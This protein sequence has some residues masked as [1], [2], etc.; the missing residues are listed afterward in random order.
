M[1]TVNIDNHSYCA[2]DV[3]QYLVSFLIN[4]LICKSEA[5]P[6]ETRVGHNLHGEH[7]FFLKRM[8]V[9]ILVGK[10]IPTDQSL[11]AKRRSVLSSCSYTCSMGTVL[12]KNSHWLNGNLT[13]EFSWGGS[14]IPHTVS[15]KYAFRLLTFRENISIILACQKSKSERS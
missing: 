7:F 3:L 13:K 6:D 2:G 14:N 10:P 1:L 9:Y 11:F 8:R 15:Y 4:I 12:A 5:D